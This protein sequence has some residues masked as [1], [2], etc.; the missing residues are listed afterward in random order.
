[1]TYFSPFHFHDFEPDARYVTRMISL[2][3]MF[4]DYYFYDHV[5]FVIPICPLHPQ[6][7][8]FPAA[9]LL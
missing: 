7:I 8:S 9:L 3:K 6:K 4:Y 1:M 2:S 5:N